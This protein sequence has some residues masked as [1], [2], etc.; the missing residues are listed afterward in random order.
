MKAY[1]IK[2][3]LIDS[4]PPIWR[5]VIMPADATFNR[6]HQTIQTVTN[7]QSDIAD[8]HLYEFMLE[9]ENLRITNDDEALEEH[10]H[11]MK[12]RKEIEERIRDNAPAEFEE[13]AEN[14]IK[15]LQMI[16]RK[17]TRIK[18]DDYLEKYKELLYMYDYGDNWMFLITLEDIMDDYKKGHPTLIDGER[19]A[20]PEDVGGIAG[21]EEFLKAYHDSSDPEHE[22][23]RE[24]AEMQNYREYDKDFINNM[25]KHVK[26][27]KSE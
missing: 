11:F 25:L 9:E 23:M 3:E 13:F 6:L 2:I 15:S 22:E 21:Y 1:Q 8:Y 14:Q 10:K 5:R 20:P 27:K 16:V 12:N 19:T 7:F 18:M 17:P 4:D 26:Y 24:W